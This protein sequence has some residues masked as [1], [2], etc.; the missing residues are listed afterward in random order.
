MSV[1]G[2]SSSSGDG[3]G[4]GGQHQ[5]CHED[6]GEKTARVVTISK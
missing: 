5:L 4:I 2:G 1:I 3:S 6:D